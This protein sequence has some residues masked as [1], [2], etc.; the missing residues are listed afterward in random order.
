[1]PVA[2]TPGA[3]P[4]PRRVSA[5][6]ITRPEWVGT[7]PD[8][9]W[10]ELVSA[11]RAEAVQIDLTD[12]S[13]SDLVYIPEAFAHGVCPDRFPA[14]LTALLYA[15]YVAVHGDPHRGVAFVARDRGDLHAEE[16]CHCVLEHAQ[17]W[18]LPGA[19]AQW[20]TKLPG[21]AVAD[22]VTHDVA[23]QLG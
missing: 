19:F 12:L 7:T 17:N 11:F 2:P 10:L 14:R 6:E 21:L 22:P 1:M 13:E 15:R 9:A 5:S 3:L 23:R 18:A 8:E 4:K 20:I 16:L